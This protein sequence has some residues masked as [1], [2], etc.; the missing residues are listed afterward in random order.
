[1]GLFAFLDAYPGL[2]LIQSFVHSVITA[3]VIEI[4]IK[5]WEIRNPLVRQRFLLIAVVFPVFSF[6]LYQAI[7][8]ER[9]SPYFRFGALFD[10][11]RWMQVEPWGVVAIIPVCL[12]VVFLVTFLVFF[13]QEFVPIVRFAF[14]SKQHRQ[15]GV[16]G[17]EN[18]VVREAIERLPGEK[19]DVFLLDDEDVVLF[20][21]TGKKGAIYLS[22]G[23]LQVLPADQVRAAIAHEYA[24]VERGRRP[25]LLLIFL[26]RILAF[27]NP[28]ALMEF[29]RVIQDDEKICDDVAT[30][31]TGNP[32]ALANALRKLYLSGENQAPGKGKTIMEDMEALETYS[33]RLN[34]ESRIA[35]LEKGYALP[36]NRKWSVIALTL[37]VV[38]VLNYFVV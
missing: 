8:P 36:Q 17:E 23:L 19:P 5:T 13:F 33:H 20:S 21:T 12:L 28:I 7:N 1:M 10:S 18:P 2:Y 3:A 24:H 6:P 25:F 4:A 22:H 9:T 15:A 32:S 30:S 14:Q 26:I 34:I 38:L 37:A 31:L 11:S 35:R 27:F 29:R 16:R